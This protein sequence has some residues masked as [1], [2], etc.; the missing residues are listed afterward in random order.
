MKSQVDLIIVARYLGNICSVVGYLIL[1]HV[2]PILGSS[3]KLVGFCFSTPFCIRLKLWDVVFLFAFF[4]I[5]DLSNLIKL[6]LF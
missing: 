1:L 3:I 4:G 2:D 6:L 5:L